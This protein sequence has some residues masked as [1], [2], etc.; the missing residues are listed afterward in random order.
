MLCEHDVHL[1][2]SPVKHPVRVR[3]CVGHRDLAHLQ[4]KQTKRLV[5]TAHSDNHLH[6]SHSWSGGLERE[7]RC[8]AAAQCD[9][10]CQLLEDRWQKRGEAASTQAS[11]GGCVV[12]A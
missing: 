9:T 11:T 1:K 2:P 6:S 5:A 10:C 8:N 7:M 4:C 3:L 12:G